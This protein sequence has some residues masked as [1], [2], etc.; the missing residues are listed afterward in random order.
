MGDRATKTALWLTHSTPQ[1]PKRNQNHFWP[2]SGAKNGQTFLCVSLPFAELGKVGQHLRYIRAYSF[3]FDLPTDFPNE[4]QNA[5]SWLFPAAG[6]TELGNFQVMSTRG[7]V[8]LKMM[9]KPTGTSVTVGDLYVKLAAGL[10][11]DV[12]VHVWGCQRD[13]SFCDRGQKQVL[14]VERLNTGIGIWQTGRDHSKWAVT[15][16]PG[17]TWTCFGDVNRKDTQYERW[18]GALCI[19][20]A[21]LNHLFKDISDQTLQCRKRPHAC[22]DDELSSGS[23]SDSSF[24]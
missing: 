13:E 23:D 10:N 16:A 20:N 17:V 3:D 14:S 5:A 24:R 18:G 12:R 2:L 22:S 6:N 9:A 21:Q 11:S 19:Q 7:S 15:T 4:L 8:E 1:F